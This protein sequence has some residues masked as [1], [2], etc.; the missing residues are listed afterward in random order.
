[1]CLVGSR[2]RVADRTQAF[3]D[4][5]VWMVNAQMLGEDHPAQLRSVEI[6][7]ELVT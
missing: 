4:S 3:A 5:G 2:A 6:L 7:K 1:M